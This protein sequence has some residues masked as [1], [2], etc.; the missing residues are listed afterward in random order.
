M[1]LEKLSNEAGVSGDEGAI[2]KIIIPAIKPHVDRVTV[3]TMG[4]VYAYKGNAPDMPT[5]MIA[6]HMDEVGVIITKINDSGMLKFELVGSFDR[7]ILPGKRVRVGKDKI[8]GVI[9]LKAI[10]FVMLSKMSQSP[11][12]ESM[13][14]DVGLKPKGISLGD[15]AVFDV[16]FGHLNSDPNDWQ[17]GV[18][19]GKAIDDRAGCAILIELLKHDY[20]VNIVG[21]FTVQEE[22]GLRGAVV[23]SQ[24]IEPDI[25]IALD[26][27]S[28]DD[29][30]FGQKKGDGYPC[31]GDGPVLVRMDKSFIADRK[32]FGRACHDHFDSKSLPS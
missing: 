22:L 21:V 7:R 19:K 1:L 18:V 23:A 29:V 30:P 4:N 3:D 27:T 11:S 32:L 28:T 24:R 10:H 16:E 5:V 25:G 12:L 15:F 14:I 13:A 9:G 17:K 8:P 26:C 2:R 20:A 6:A 31:L